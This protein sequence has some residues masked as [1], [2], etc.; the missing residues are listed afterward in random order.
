MPKKSTAMIHGI[1]S[2]AVF[3]VFSFYLAGSA[4]GSVFNAIGNTLSRTASLAADGIGAVAGRDVHQRQLSLG[5]RID[6]GSDPASRP[7]LTVALD[8][9]E[10]DDGT[11]STGEV[12]PSIGAG[13]ALDTGMGTVS[14]DL[15]A[16]EVA[17]DVRRY[18]IDL[19]YEH[20][21]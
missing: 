16:S 12:A 15:S 19:R 18:G 7:Y 13:Y 14:V 6:F 2:W 17:R 8:G 4:T 20:R 5:T 1:L 3:S 9:Y 10:F 11:D 21:F